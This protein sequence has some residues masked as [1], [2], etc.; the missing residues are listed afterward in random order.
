LRLAIFH[1]VASLRFI[2]DLEIVTCVG[3]ALEAEDFDR[4]RRWRR[5]RGAPAIIKHRA[6]F[7]ENRAADEEVA[8][9]QR[10]VLNQDRRD[11]TAA[12]VD[13]RFQYSADSRRVRIRLELTQ[14]GDEQQRLEELVDTGLILRRDFDQFGVAAPLRG[15]QTKVSELTLDA[16][17]L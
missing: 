3:R 16:L 11:R 14:I 7:S 9:V 10:A 12:L 13:A 2:S 17:R 5:F 6:H 4:G 1:D 15:Q 8:G